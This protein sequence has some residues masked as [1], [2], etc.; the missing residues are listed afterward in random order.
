MWWRNN[1]N[2]TA[3]AKLPDAQAETFFSNACVH[4]RIIWLEVKEPAWQE[5][6]Q[7]P[8]AQMM[9]QKK[10]FFQKSYKGSSLLA[11]L[12]SSSG[13]CERRCFFSQCWPDLV[14]TGQPWLLRSPG[15][16]RCELALLRG[17][18]GQQCLELQGLCLCRMRPSFPTLWSSE[19]FFH[20]V[21]RVPT[22]KAVILKQWCWNW[23]HLVHETWPLAIGSTYKLGKRGKREAL[24]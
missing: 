6:A 7:R 13:S 9:A 20:L 3:K 14:K 19:F 17:I 4:I 1:G 5:A 24:V 21:L 10:R 11:I 22:L 18:L 12:G 23:N 16:C 15:N 8:F 2:A